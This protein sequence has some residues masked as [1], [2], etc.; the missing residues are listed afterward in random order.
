MNDIHG[1]VQRVLAFDDGDSVNDAIDLL[2]VE[3]H[4]SGHHPF[5]QSGF[6]VRVREDAALMPPGSEPTRIAVDDGTRSVMATGPGWI[7]CATR[8]QHGNARVSVV[9]ES[10]QLAREVFELAIRDAQVPPSI[11]RSKADVGFWH[12]GPRGPVRTERSLGVESWS[13]IRRNY[14]SG[15]AKA[16][17][18]LM[19]MSCGAL[20]GKLLLL[21]GPPRHR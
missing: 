15:T 2:F 11:D 10:A 9:A 20:P 1:S 4:I 17:D 18:G 12:I 8:W 6:L 19:T 16:L 14:A 21:H 3:Q 7:L 13:G 5:A